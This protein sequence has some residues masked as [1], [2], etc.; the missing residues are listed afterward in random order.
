MPEAT[1]GGSEF[2]ALFSFLSMFMSPFHGKRSVLIFFIQ[3]YRE[4][5]ISKGRAAGFLLRGSKL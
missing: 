4:A 3:T 2:R 1:D 5:E